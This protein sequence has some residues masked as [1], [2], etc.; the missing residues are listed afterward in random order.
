[1]S[2]TI[3]AR[4]VFA[5]IPPGIQG[6]L[7]QVVSGGKDVDWM[8]FEIKRE[9]TNAFIIKDGKILLGYKKRGFG[10]GMYNGFGGKV[11]PGESSLQGAL[12][13]LKEEAGITAPLEHAGTLLFLSEGVDHAF[14]IEIYRA[15]AYSGV[16]T[17]SV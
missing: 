6:Y 4:E 3:E 14:N 16:V 7:K 13:E 12:R 17:E 1:M 15:D 10:V 11:E 5:V 2:A 8:P 9:Y